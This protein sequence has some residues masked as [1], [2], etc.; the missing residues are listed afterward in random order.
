MASKGKKFW[1]YELAGA[2]LTERWSGFARQLLGEGGEWLEFEDRGTSRYRAAL[3]E[4]DRIESC[5]FVSTSVQLP[6]RSWLGELFCAASLDETD[7]LSLLAGR[8]PEG[9]MDT[10]ETICSCFGVGRNTIL[11]AL[12][13]RRLDSVDSIVVGRDGLYMRRAGERGGLLLP[14]VPVEQ[15][16]SLGEFLTGLCHKAGYADGA[17]GDPDMELYR[18]SA[19]VFGE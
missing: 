5:L 6:G 17:W 4:D 10:G 13:D 9:S 8:P 19:Q 7:R 18:F 15:G 2:L 1:R 3:I 12:R 14:Q 11:R 16:W